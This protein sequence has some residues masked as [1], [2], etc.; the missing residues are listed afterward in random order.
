MADIFHDFPIQASAARV[1][2]AIAT[3]GGIDEWWSRTCRGRP[4]LGASYEL[5]FGPGFDWTA[6]V[7]RCVPDSEFELQFVEA[8]EDWM[9]ARVGFQ[10]REVDGSTQV[11][12]YHKGWPEPNEHYRVSCFCWAMYLRLLKRYVERGERVPWDERL[13]A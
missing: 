9:G 7:T 6:R 10:L 11:S 5:S 4:E 2:E 12:F 8:D 3:P 1:F 13:D